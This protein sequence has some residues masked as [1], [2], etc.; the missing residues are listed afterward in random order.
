LAGGPL[1]GGLL[2]GGLLAGGDWVPWLLCR[3]APPFCA[4]GLGLLGLAG[5]GLEPVLAG[6][7]LA[8]LLV[9]GLRL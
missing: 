2:A 1:A 8:G 9:L 5:G 7:G 6:L 3:V 4:A